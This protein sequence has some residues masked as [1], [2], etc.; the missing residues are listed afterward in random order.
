MVR[1]LKQISRSILLLMVTMLIVT[2]V[3][4]T[5]TAETVRDYGNSMDTRISFDFDLSTYDKERSDIPAEYTVDPAGTVRTAY[6]PNSFTYFDGSKYSIKVEIKALG[7]NKYIDAGNE[8]IANGAGKEHKGIKLSDNEIV[9]GAFGLSYDI[10][11]SFYK[12][13]KYTIPAN[14]YAAVAFEDPDQSNYLFTGA[15]TKGIYYMDVADKDHGGTMRL[16][17]NY[18]VNGSGITHVSV[19]DDYAYN[20]WAN[21]DDGLFAVLISNGSTFSYEVEGKQ[22][23]LRVMV[24]LLEV[25]VPY[26]VEYYYEVEGAYPENP[27]YSSE[28]IYVD[29][30]KHPTVSV[31]EADK[32]PNPEKGDGYVLDTKMNSAWELAVAPDGSTVLKVYFY[33]PYTIKYDANGGT[34]T[35]ADDNYKGTD[36]TMP[37][38]EEWTFTREGYEFIGYKVENEG[39]LLNGSKEYRPELLKEEDRTI[40]LFAQ[41]K[42]LEYKIVYHKNADD[43]VGEMIDSV[44][45]GADASM[46]SK[47]E[48]TFTRKGYKFIGYKVDDAGEI[49]NGSNEYRPELLVDAD[50][51]IHLYAQWEELPYK[52]RYNANGG[53][54][55][56]KDDDYKGSD[57]SMPS[58]EEW[59]FTWEGHD[60]LGFKLEDKGEILN[61]KQEYVDVLLDEE[62]REIVLYAQWDP[63]KYTIKY[64]PNGGIGEMPDHIYTYDDPT[65]NS[66]PNKFVRSGYIFTGF[67]YTDKDGN[68]TLYKT[69]EDFRSELV[70]LGKNSEIL[71][72]AQWRKEPVNTVIPIPLT[73]VE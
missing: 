8:A 39:D 48:W 2:M 20:S 52:I 27:D 51:T 54:G 25:I 41:W 64:D 36:S 33:L 56:M 61:G 60:F 35:M 18:E 32:K 68:Q 65:M 37:S 7:E 58:K 67:L 22:D 71:L 10:A 40:T 11:F 38:K 45:T 4:V 43:S 19:D 49:L 53:T 69:I 12:D 23:N 59:T 24:D 34:G 44:Y 42:P 66:D 63:W 1:R 47:E 62:D 17:D 57:T 16:I 9:L 14:V 73:G 55:T 26:R 46:P 15:E 70:K 72:V 13:D 28:L 21:F 6:Y 31:T 30:Y 50:R 29:I 3:P 5:I